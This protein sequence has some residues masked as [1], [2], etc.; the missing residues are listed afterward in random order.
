MKYVKLFESW[1]NEEEGGEDIKNFNPEKP[2][3]WP[4]LQTTANQLYQ[5]GKLDQKILDSILGRANQKGGKEFNSYAEIKTKYFSGFVIKD[6]S[7]NIRGNN[8]STGNNFITALKDAKLK[9]DKN[10]VLKTL[11]IVGISLDKELYSIED[12]SDFTTNPNTCT[13]I[14]PNVPA[15]YTYTSLE[16]FMVTKLPVVVIYEGESFNTTIGNVLSFIHDGISDTQLLKEDQTSNLSKL[17]AGEGKETQLAFEKTIAGVR[18]IAAKNTK[19]KPEDPNLIP[20]TPVILKDRYI[21]QIRFDFDSDKLTEQAEKELGGESDMADAIYNVLTRL[22]PE[23][24][25]EIVGHAD[26]MGEKQYNIDLSKRRAASVL[27]YLEN[28]DWWKEGRVKA[29]VTT[30]GV[31]F[32]EPIVNDDGGKKPIEATLNRRVEFRIDGKKPDYAKI[33]QELGIK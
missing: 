33:K 17:F 29:K 21:G 7:L 28:L 8:L 23:Q 24:T 30:T 14:I 25:V 22:K 15:G 5:N 10:Q 11:S 13:M 32:S 4:V 26:G 1:L 19:Q 9:F 31:G 16:K 18:F 27:K 2:Q 6:T 20:R 12:Y 3:G